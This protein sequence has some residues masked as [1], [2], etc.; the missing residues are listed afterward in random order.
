[1]RYYKLRT[2]KYVTRVSIALSVL[3]NVILGGKSNQTF[4]A[5]NFYWKIQGR[6]NV[7]WLIDRIFW[8]DPHHCLNSWVYWRTAKNIR[9]KQFYKEITENYVRKDIIFYKMQE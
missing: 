7:V 8:F 9:K 1:M 6:Y 2:I 5:R 3:L 4:S